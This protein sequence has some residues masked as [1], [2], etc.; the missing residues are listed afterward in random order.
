MWTASHLSQCKCHILRFI[1]YDREKMWWQTTFRHINKDYSWQNCQLPWQSFNTIYC[2]LNDCSYLIFKKT[3]CDKIIY[4]DTTQVLD[5]VWA[6]PGPGL[7]APLQE[8][9]RVP[10]VRVQEPGPRAS[11]SGLLQAGEHWSRPQNQ[12]GEQMSISIRVKQSEP[13]H[14]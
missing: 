14:I 13:I 3:R 7:W 8:G 1:F 2:F 12:T 11:A 6:R 9:P 10:R 5:A 4:Q